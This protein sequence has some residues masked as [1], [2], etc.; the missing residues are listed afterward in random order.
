MRTILTCVA[1]LFVA[2][3]GC[4][5]PMVSVDASLG[6]DGGAN[7]ASANDASSLPDVFVG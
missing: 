1:L 2:M 4:T 5:T 6:H 7:D 3:P